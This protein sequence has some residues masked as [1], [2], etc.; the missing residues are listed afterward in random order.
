MRGLDLTA[1]YRILSNRAPEFYNERMPKVRATLFL[2]QRS[3]LY[4]RMDIKLFKP[5]RR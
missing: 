1:D 3:P 2:W 5:V 4:Y